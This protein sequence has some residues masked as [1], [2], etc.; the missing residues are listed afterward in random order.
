MIGDHASEATLEEMPIRSG[1]WDDEERLGA[2]LSVSFAADPFVRWLM[3]NSLDFLH[4]SQKHPRRAYSAAFDA[5]TIFAI[6]DFAGAAVWLAPGARTDRSEEIAQAEPSVA[7]SGHGFPPEF[8]ALISQSAAYRPSEPHW[9]LGL[10][11]V[12][13][14][15]RGRGLGA[16]LMEHCLTFVDRDGLPAYL[17]STNA[18]NRSLYRRFGFEQLAEVRV[19][20]APPRFP[21]L[22]PARK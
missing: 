20:A 17:E 4:D 16:K 5:G 7:G 10:I 15:Y 8:A 2:L 21:M 19:G 18:A 12:D 13:P 3:P 1:G 9:Y 6:G 14:A 11:A 22:R